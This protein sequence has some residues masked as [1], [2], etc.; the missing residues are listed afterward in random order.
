[1]TH[2]RLIAKRVA[3]VALDLSGAGRALRRRMAGR[4]LILAYHNV[5]PDHEVLAEFSGHLGASA[6]EA[7]MRSLARLADVVPVTA[8]AAQPAPS[9]RP[10]VAITFDDGYRGAFRHAVPVLE[11]L[12]LPAT[13]FVC[14]GLMGRDAFWWDTPNL[15]VWKRRGDVLER[16]Q[17][18]G[19]RVREWIASQGLVHGDDRPDFMPASEAEVMAFAARPGISIGSHTVSHPNLSQLGEDE[20][21]RELVESRDALSARFPSYVPWVAYPFGLANPM[22][23]RVTAEEGY[24]GGFVLDG[25]WIRPGAPITALTRL[26][27][28]AGLSIRGFRLRLAG[29]FAR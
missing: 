11:A 5:V 7:Q 1:V 20:V 8:L 13:F 12:G 10:R 25:G 16:L 6:F 2:P 23:E 14:P 15:A 17:G 19:A 28:A 29:L 24:V 18:R 4:D 27:I 22:V 21:R 26:N 3:E 9:R